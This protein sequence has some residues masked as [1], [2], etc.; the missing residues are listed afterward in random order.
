MARAKS[1]KIK[2]A[3]K[4]EKA[5]K[6]AKAE[7]KKPA[8]PEKPSPA[9]SEKKVTRGEKRKQRKEKGRRIGLAF[10]PP[11]KTCNDHRCP[12]HGKISIRGR[13]FRAVVRSSKSHSTAVVEWGYHHYF[14]KYE[15]YERR[16][17]R[18]TAHN[19]PCIRARDGDR[20]MIAECR[21][22]SKT[23]KFVI[24]GFLKKD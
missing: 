6:A 3:K 19:P 18:V 14:P 11:E 5:G 9:K 13:A 23:K 2:A 17:S 8:S 22:L 12:W 4:E 10:R 21:P 20:V 7:K 15:R 24:V 16:K 1:S